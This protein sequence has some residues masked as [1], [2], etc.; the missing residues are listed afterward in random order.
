[1]SS[2]AVCS[3]V[4]STFRR[5]ATWG[6]DLG[7][8]LVGLACCLVVHVPERDAEEPITVLEPGQEPCLVVAFRRSRLAY[9]SQAAAAPLH[10]VH[11]LEEVGQHGVSPDALDFV[12]GDVV[13]KTAVSRHDARRA[14]R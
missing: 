8:D 3:P 13:G 6:G 7:G 11:A 14:Y 2:V 5:L 1:M 10:E 12:A 4:A 9:L